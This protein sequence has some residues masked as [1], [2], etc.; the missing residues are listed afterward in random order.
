VG[1][2]HGFGMTPGVA[3]AYLI[4]AVFLFALSRKPAMMT[5][6]DAVPAE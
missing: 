1:I 4:M 6:P 2:G 3:L 5:V